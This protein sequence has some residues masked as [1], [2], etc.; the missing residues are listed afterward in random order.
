MG[1]QISRGSYVQS[2]TRA[3]SILDELRS[4]G[5]PCTPAELARSLGLD[6]TVV[7]RL[8]RTLAATGILMENSGRY[9]LGPQNVLYSNSYLDRLSIRR[10]ALPYAIELQSRVIKD[11]PWVTALSVYAGHSI[12]IIDRIW[13]PETPLESILDVGT[14]FPLEG[15]AGGRLFLAYLPREEAVAL[16]GETKVRE[17]EPRFEAIRKAGGVDIALGDASPGV[18]AVS[19]AIFARSGSVVASF[20]VTGPDMDAVLDRES[21]LAVRLRRAA[22]GIGAALASDG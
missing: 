22:D 7:Y 18:G 11:N 10:I 12:T 8:V 17:F 4:V 16:V 9:F 6:R 3:V 14:T 5:R 21:D 20:A 1:Q 13:S 19:A 15:S 2:V